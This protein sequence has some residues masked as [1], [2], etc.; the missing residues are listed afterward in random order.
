M[1][2][3]SIWNTIQEWLT[4]TGIKVVIS[5]AILVVSFGLINWLAK[6]LAAKGKKI[7]QNKNVDKTIYRTLSYVTKIALKILIVVALIGYL[8]IDT[9]GITALIASLGVGIGLAVNGTL[10]NFAGGVLLL[11]TRPFKVDDYIAACGYEGTVEEIRICNTKIKTSDNKVVYLP[12][13]TLST[14]EIVNYSEKE[15]RRVDLVFSVSYSDD[16]EKAKQIIKTVC[17]NNPLAV[18][19]PAASVRMSAHSQNGVELTAKVW[20]KNADYHT[21][22]ADLLEEVKREFDAQGVSIPVGQMDVRLRRE[23]AVEFPTEQ[24]D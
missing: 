8:G 6:K 20:C 14:T 18:D 16:F 3:A 17:D 5:L 4:H 9:S 1:D 21:L 10:S 19:E 22:K 12:N 23:T 7:E 24:I 15:L 2:W 11:I 13:G